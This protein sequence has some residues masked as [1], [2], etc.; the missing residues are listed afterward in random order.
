MVI[1]TNSG[2][3]ITISSNIISCSDG[4]MYNI[5]GNCLTGF[6]GFISYNIKS[7][8]EAIG[9]IIGMYGGKRI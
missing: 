2:V 6:D 4:K 1:I 3:T 5:V 7:Q 9:I 8:D